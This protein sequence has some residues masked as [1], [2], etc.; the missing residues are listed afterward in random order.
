MS[1]ADPT[2][3]QVNSGARQGKA[4]PASYKTPA[5]VLITQKYAWLMTYLQ[6]QHALVESIDVTLELSVLLRR[7]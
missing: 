7:P 1:N 4:V 3:N 5:I 2:K 6:L